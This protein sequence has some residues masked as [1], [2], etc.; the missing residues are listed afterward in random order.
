M[1]KP[2]LLPETA[3]VNSIIVSALSHVISGRNDVEPSGSGIGRSSPEQ[4]VCRFCGMPTPDCLG[5]DFFPEERRKRRGVSLRPSGKWAAEIMVP[6]KERKWLG[7]FE[8]E[9]EA[10]RAYDIA[11]IRYRGRSAKTNFP[12]EEYPESQPEMVNK[13]VE[14]FKKRRKNRG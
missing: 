2:S 8:T 1:N 5:C 13:E 14:A 10:A 11:N 12:V 4:E 9:E 6:G 3:D 7:T